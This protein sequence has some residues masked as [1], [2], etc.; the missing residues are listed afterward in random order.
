MGS[1]WM[2]MLDSDSTPS[3]FDETIAAVDSLTQ[4]AASGGAKIVVFQESTMLIEKADEEQ[5]LAQLGSI[6][7]EH[8]VFLSFTYVVV[9]SVAKGENRQ[10]FLN[11]G[12][13]IE[14]NYQ[15]RYL[16]GFGSLGET[17]Y[18]EKGPGI[19]PVVETPYGNIGF[20]ICRD[21]SFAPYVRQLSSKNVDIVLD[22]SDDF[23]RSKG[24]V[25]LQR[26][27]EGGF[28][29]IRPTRNGIS[30]AADFHGNVLASKDYFAT[31]NE[32]MYADVPTSGKTTLY[33][34]VGDAFGW[35]CVLGFG[36]CVVV[37]IRNRVSRNDELPGMTR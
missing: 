36:T 14:A 12:G 2:E 8:S 13:A 34:I 3:M 28:S 4:Q 22:P 27:I 18:L 16:L 1:N 35:L 23:P 26:A 32:I 5:L 15:K 37:A 6:A 7:G 25:S 30:F 19:L 9:D 10:V 11:N 31:A 29:I 17:A 20:G 24:H 33:A 21:M